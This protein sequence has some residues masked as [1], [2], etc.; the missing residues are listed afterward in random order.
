VQCVY[1]TW[2]W[3]YAKDATMEPQTHKVNYR[4]QVEG[5]PVLLVHGYGANINP[6]R[7]QFPALVAVGYR[8]YAIDLLGC[9]ASD[10]KK[11][12]QR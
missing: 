11:C 12:W 8:V 3:S 7:H 2:Y 5:P 4:V 9:G 10:K 6:F 1:D